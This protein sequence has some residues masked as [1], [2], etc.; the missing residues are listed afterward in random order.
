M[1]MILSF[2]LSSV[3]LYAKGNDN[4]VHACTI[5]EQSQL[6]VKMM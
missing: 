1:A 6:T 2:T 5:K 4:R 3:N